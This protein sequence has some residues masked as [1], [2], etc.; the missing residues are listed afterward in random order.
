MEP[1]FS[2]FHVKEEPLLQKGAIHHLELGGGNSLLCL[3]GW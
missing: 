1:P 2:C 3:T